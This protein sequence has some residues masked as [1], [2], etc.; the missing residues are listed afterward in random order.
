MG[1]V[2]GLDGA[3]VESKISADATPEAVLV[4]LLEDIRSKNIDVIRL[5]IAVECDAGYFNRSSCMT[6]SEAVTLT[7]IAT[8]LT[9]DAIIDV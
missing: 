6:N 2:V 4:K 3:A 1:S 8:R 5:V 7:T 9:V